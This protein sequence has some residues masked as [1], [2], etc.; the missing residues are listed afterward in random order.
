MPTMR[1]TV[2]TTAAYPVLPNYPPTFDNL[3]ATWRSFTPQFEFHRG[4]PDDDLEQNELT[5]L[6]TA[7]NDVDGMAWLK[8]RLFYRCTSCFYRA[9]DLFLATLTLQRRS[10]RT[11]SDVTAYYSRFYSIQA[12]MNLLLT[13]YFRHHGSEI[14]IYYT[15]TE[16]RV[17][18]ARDLPPPIRNTRGS[19]E[20]WWLL[21]ETIKV[22]MDYP[23]QHLGFVLSRAYYDPTQRNTINYGFDYTWGGFPELNWC[24]TDVRN[25]MAHFHPDVREDKDITN[26]A[27]FFANDDPEWA[28]LADFGGDPIQ[29][30]WLSLLTIMELITALGIQQ[31][32]IATP[33]IAA[34]TEVHLFHDY[35]GLPRGSLLK[36]RP[37]LKTEYNVAEHLSV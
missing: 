3:R 32:F 29:V 23:G 4:H 11:W 25:M 27:R 20:R 22:P 1:H 31:F 5:D 7:L 30:V 26:E 10:F 34:L 36:L 33:K 2:D 6:P 8:Q 14:L 18:T 35:P 19:H 9:L 24:D 17:L 28:D 16:A 13:S 21:M 15:G 12:I 37:L